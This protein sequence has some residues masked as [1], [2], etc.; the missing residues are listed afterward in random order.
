MEARTILRQRS[1]ER[2]A[3]IAFIVNLSIAVTGWADEPPTKQGIFAHFEAESGRINVEFTDREGHCRYALP[4][5]PITIDGASQTEFHSIG[6]G[7]DI[8]T[9]T[10]VS[11]ELDHTN[12]AS[13]AII[14]QA[15]NGARPM[16]Q[17]HYHSDFWGPV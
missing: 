9:N 2:V 16:T 12:R 6:F 17:N 8:Y 1:F 14:W 7:R 10:K 15:S 3:I 13:T 5:P 4:L 11:V